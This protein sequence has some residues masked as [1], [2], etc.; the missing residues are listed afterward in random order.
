MNLKK[1]IRV[2]ML[3][4]DK[5][6]GIGSI[7]KMIDKD[8]LWDDNEDFI[9]RLF[10]NVNPLVNKSN[11]KFQAQHLYFLSDEEI[12][13]GDWFLTDDRL[14]IYENNG[15]PIW[16]LHKCTS[17]T[18]KWI[19]ADND[20]SIGYNPNWSKKINASTDKS[21]NL[22]EPSPSFI[23]KFIEEWNKGNKITEVMVEYEKLYSYEATDQF[24]EVGFCGIKPKID[25][26]NQ[27]TITKVKDSWSKEEVAK[28]I[29]D[30]AKEFSFK[31]NLEFK[32]SL[33]FTLKWI[34]E[35]L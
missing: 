17:I 10:I 14:N 28:Q 19:K 13:E 34:S 6:A 16:E 23:Q 5:E 24:D 31:N 1:K 3:S 8:I 26:N 21:L 22:P 27:I 9:G 35:N 20:D 29:S 30:F 18:N 2:I 12:K 15:I 4:T 7:Y 25:K 33:D 11:H 32:S